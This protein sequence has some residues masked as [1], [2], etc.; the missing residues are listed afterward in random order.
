MG[1]KFRELEIWVAEMDDE[2]VGWG[3]IRAN[4]LEGLYTDPS[5]AD[6]GIGTALLRMLEGLIQ[7]RGNLEIRTIASPNAEDF[8]IRRGYERIGPYNPS[9]GTLMCKRFAT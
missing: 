4:G 2:I 6:R 3:A 9:K 1:K 5:F 8:Y 7:A